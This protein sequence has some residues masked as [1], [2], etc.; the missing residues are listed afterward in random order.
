[1]TP[2]TLQNITDVAVN[3]LGNNASPRTKEVIGGLI[4]HLHAF[5]KEV[6]L[7]PAE[8]MEGINFLTA[9]GQI[10]TEKRQE[11][12]LLSD[13]L[14]V[15]AVVDL[16]AHSNRHHHETESTLLGPFYR[17]GVAEL[18]NGSS[19]AMNTAGDPVIVRGRICDNTGRPIA[20]ARVETWHSDPGGFYDVQRQ[21]DD[22]D[23]RGIFRSDLEGRFE[24]QTVKT[25]SYPV[26]T[27]GPVGRL[28]NLCGRHPFRPA[29]YHF[30]ISAQGYEQLTTALY[31]AGDPYLESD[32]VYGVR[33]SLVV[34]YKHD[35]SLP[36]V[37]IVDYNFTL[38]DSPNSQ[39]TD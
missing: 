7:T 4:R 10:T 26:P 33:E 20:G 18:E 16:V 35:S 30:Q 36:G 32:A 29:H 3:Q 6:N 8:W 17:E 31:V 15:S 2:L 9:C 12:I 19:I 27:D 11:M 1:M 13:T 14:A 5:V 28:L 23:L 37:S 38:A 25:H 24:F 21:L 34:S 39:A 22:I